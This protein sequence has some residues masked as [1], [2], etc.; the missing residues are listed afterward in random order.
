MTM[1]DIENELF[2]K[3][4]MNGLVLG[5]EN[6]VRLMDLSLDAGTTSDIVPAKMNKDGSF[7]KNS[8]IANRDEFKEI[9]D[10]LHHYM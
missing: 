7:A 4:K 2:K 1:E 5:E 6:A 9:S 3:F 8:K 10:Y